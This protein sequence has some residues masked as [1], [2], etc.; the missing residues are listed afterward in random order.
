MEGLKMKKIKKKRKQKRIKIVGPTQKI[1]KI[2]GPAQKW[3]DPKEVAKALGAEI[4]GQ[5]KRRNKRHRP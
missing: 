3:V 2:V 4:I 5:R 1:I